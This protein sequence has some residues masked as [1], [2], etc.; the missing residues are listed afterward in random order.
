MILISCSYSRKFNGT[1]KNFFESSLIGL[2]EEG[3]PGAVI[4]ANKTVNA[5]RGYS[6]KLRIEHTA[7]GN[8]LID[9]NELELDLDTRKKI[10][11]A[12]RSKKAKPVLELREPSLDAL[13]VA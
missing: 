7:Q 2:V 13:E 1:K 3:H 5:D 11:D 4:F 8:D 12:I 9:I 10:L 6:E